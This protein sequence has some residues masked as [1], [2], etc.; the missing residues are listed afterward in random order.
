MIIGICG[1]GFVG[2]AVYAFMNNDGNKDLVSEDGLK[3]ESVDCPL[4]LNSFKR[5]QIIK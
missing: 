2:G 3:T 4:S 1:L 5:L